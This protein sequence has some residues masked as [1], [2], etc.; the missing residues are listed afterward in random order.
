MPKETMTPRERWLA[1]FKRETPDRVPMDYWSTPEFSAKLIRHMGLSRLSHKRLVE[2]LGRGERQPGYLNEAKCALRAALAQ[3][4]VDFVVSARP[5]YVGPP[6]PPNSDVYGCVY[7]SIDYGTGQYSEV[8][9][10]PL[11]RFQSVDESEAN[12][13]WPSPD[14]YDY[15]GIPAQIKG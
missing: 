12:Y 2:L 5:R 4:H 15:S 8:I 10:N 14:W 13:R 7:H 9:T 1:V 6:L 11:A 3:L